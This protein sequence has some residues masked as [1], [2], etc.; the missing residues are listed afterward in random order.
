MGMIHR[1]NRNSI[2]FISN[3]LNCT[4]VWSLNLYDKQTNYLWIWSSRRR[5]LLLCCWCTRSGLRLCRWLLCTWHMHRRCLWMWCSGNWM[6]NRRWMRL[7]W[8]LRMWL[9]NNTNNILPF[10]LIN[11]VKKHVFY[12]CIQN[13]T[14]IGCDWECG[15]AFG[16]P[17]PRKFCCGGGPCG[18]AAPISFCVGGY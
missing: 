18:G 16:G 5:A 14:G 12:K 9:N 17:A 10:I 1:L 4:R 11:S 7:N 8:R 6:W 13:Y 15:I 2:I 3:L